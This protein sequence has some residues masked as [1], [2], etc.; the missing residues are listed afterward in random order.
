MVAGDFLVFKLRQNGLFYL[1]NGS[2]FFWFGHNY[3][4]EH[5]FRLLRFSVEDQPPEPLIFQLIVMLNSMLF[6]NLLHNLFNLFC[7]IERL[8]RNYGDIVR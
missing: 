7:N 8:F 4:N 1:I 5:L 6:I 3:A 2:A